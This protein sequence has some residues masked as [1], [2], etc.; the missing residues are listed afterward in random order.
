VR[1][2][3]GGLD[4]LSPDWLEGADHYMVVLWPGP[5]REPAVLVPPDH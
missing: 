5:E 4:T 3:F 2:Y 1:A